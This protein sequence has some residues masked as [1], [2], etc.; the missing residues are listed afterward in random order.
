MA[1]NTL[2]AYRRDLLRVAA[3]AAARAT[4]IAAL[5]GAD[6]EALVRDAMTSGLSPT[7]TARLVASTR[8]FFRYLLKSGAIGANPAD[9]LHAP[10]TL[11]SLPRFL[12]IEDVDA[13]LAAPDLSTPIGV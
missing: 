4:P 9:D 3:F 7:S 6:L 1:A 10:R 12:S 5:S 11:S 13:L 8:G 2:D